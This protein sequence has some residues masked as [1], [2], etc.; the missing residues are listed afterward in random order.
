MMPF[1]P[2]PCP[3]H[4]VRV[5]I[6]GT[7]IKTVVAASCFCFTGLTGE[8]VNAVA[9]HHLCLACLEGMVT[10]L[11]CSRPSILNREEGS[12]PLLADGQPTLVAAPVR[13][14]LLGLVPLSL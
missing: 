4:P 14:S 13:L 10:Q 2:S 7:P 9:C 11:T 12:I 6:K 3:G 5:F 8:Y 1:L